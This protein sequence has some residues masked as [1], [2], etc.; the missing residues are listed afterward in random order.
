MTPLGT[1]ARSVV[2][3][4]A[5]RAIARARDAFFNAVY[6]YGPDSDEAMDAARR[7]RVMAE[8]WDEA[9]RDG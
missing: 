9:Q 6:R 5:E 1:V 3:Q 4:A 7:F 2:R 8:I